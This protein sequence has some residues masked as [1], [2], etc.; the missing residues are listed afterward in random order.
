M[1]RQLTEADIIQTVSQ[2]QRQ[3]ASEDQ[4]KQVIG[5]MMKGEIEMSRSDG[6]QMSKADA[7]APAA[8]E[9][10][11]SKMQD[12]YSEMMGRQQQKP[13]ANGFLPTTADMNTQVMPIVSPNS[14]V[15]E[16][17]HQTVKPDGT[18]VIY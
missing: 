9:S 12:G 10:A 11:Y 15:A 3:G 5:A 7:E 18:V 4:I 14:S 1:N 17:R 8:Y 2:L 6:V 16:P 13:M